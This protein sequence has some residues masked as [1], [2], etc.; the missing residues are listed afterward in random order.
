MVMGLLTDYIVLSP[1]ITVLQVRVHKYITFTV[2]HMQKE[3][4]QLY[5]TLVCRAGIID[6]EAATKYL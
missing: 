5:R 3:T 4:R 6:S 2:Q 1:S